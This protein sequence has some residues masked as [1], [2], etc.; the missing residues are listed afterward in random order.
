[1]ITAAMTVLS[2][3]PYSFLITMTSDNESG[4]LARLVYSGPINLNIRTDD[5][6]L[7]HH[8]SLHWGKA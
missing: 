8:F 7:S 3:T 4:P 1:M 2:A 6:S 5:L